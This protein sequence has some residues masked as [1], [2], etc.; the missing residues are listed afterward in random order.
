M[1]RCRKRKNVSSIKAKLFVDPAAH[2]RVSRR[3]E[4]KLG[5]IKESDW[6]Q[7][8]D[9]RAPPSY[10]TRI[11]S[12]ETTICSAFQVIQALYVTKILSF[13]TA[14]LGWMFGGTVLGRGGL[15]CPPSKDL[16]KSMVF[17]GALAPDVSFPNR[18]KC[19]GIDVSR[20]KARKKKTV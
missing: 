14:A 18:E 17:Q 13:V 1:P 11:S 20:A 3:Q 8:K 9:R 16:S 2:G 15:L 7:T 12:F 6:F 4:M 5:A 10:E 19:A